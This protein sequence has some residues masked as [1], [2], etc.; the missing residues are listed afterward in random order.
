MM[1][2]QPQPKGVKIFI[3]GLQAMGPPA[4]DVPRERDPSFAKLRFRLRLGRR[5]F[6]TT[7]ISPIFNAGALF[8]FIVQGLGFVAALF[9]LGPKKLTELSNGAAV[10]LTA[11]ATAMSCWAFIHAIATPFRV[12]KAERS[13][14]NWQG[15]RFVYAV[16][17]RVLTAQWT[18]AENENVKM[19]VVPDVEPGALVD[20]KIEIDGPTDRLNCVVL[21]AY[22]FHPASEML[23]TGRF[24]LHGRVR[25]RKD[26]S[27]GL[28]CF[29]KPDTLPAIVRVYILAWE[30]DNNVWVDYTDLKTNTR[31]VLAPPSPSTVP[32][33]DTSQSHATL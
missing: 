19:F 12:L 2:R 24:A 33:E 32:P 9:L 6:W 23:S 3:S 27:L 8:K 30:I 1:A 17:Q 15:A 26:G 10:S 4:S 20:Y 28:Y 7:F 22:Y 13:I 14:G 29:S 31:V 11:F 16:P 5:L 25:L 18:P 21:G